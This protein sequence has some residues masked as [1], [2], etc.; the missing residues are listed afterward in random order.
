MSGE[1]TQKQPEHVGHDYVFALICDA[2][3]DQKLFIGGER[4]FGP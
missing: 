2:R 1:N 3:L 4:H